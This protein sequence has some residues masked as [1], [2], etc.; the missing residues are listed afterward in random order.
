MMEL[1]HLQTFVIV[2]EEKSITLAA[3]RLFTTPSS[4]SVQIKTLEDELGVQLFIRNARGMQITDKGEVLLQKAHETLEAVRNFVNHATQIRANLMGDVALGLNAPLNFLRI[5][6]LIQKLN[7]E[8]PGIKLHLHHLSSGRVVERVLSERLDLGFVFG[9]LADNRLSSKA[10]YQAEIVIASPPTWNLGQ[11][12]WETLSR[13][14]WICSD[15]YCP[16]QDLIENEFKK[17]NLSYKQSIQSHDEVSKADF[18]MAGI[19]LALLERSEAE[20]YAKMDKLKIVPGITFQSDL[21]LIYLR[22][23]LYDPLIVALRDLV[24]DLW[25]GSAGNPADGEVQ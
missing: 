22:Q 17:H 7:A 20:H 14:P 11:F 1:T 21:S 5:P 19:G 15:Y 3:R 9:N 24:E 18:V 16:F 13:Y 10:L 8:S 6:N 23:R 12:D 4:I 25:S 2:A